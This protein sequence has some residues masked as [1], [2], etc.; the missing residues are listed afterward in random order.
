[1]H[2]AMAFTWGGFMI[3]S[4]LGLMLKNRKSVGNVITMSVVSSVVFYAVSNFGVWVT[5]W[6]PRT[7]SGLVD[8]YI[9]GLPFLRDFTV[10]TLVYS[11]GLFGIY[12]SVAHLMQ[13]KKLAKV[14]L[15][16]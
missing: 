7:L 6:Y 16:K 9:M 13:G 12:E 4:M 10:A 3:I 15:T 14:L 8:C 5:G 2:S 1:M 11:A